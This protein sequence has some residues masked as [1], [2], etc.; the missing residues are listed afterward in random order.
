[1]MFIGDKFFGGEEPAPRESIPDLDEVRRLELAP[2]PP[3]CIQTFSAEGDFEY[4]NG[5]RVALEYARRSDFAS[6]LAFFVNTSAARGGAPEAWRRW[7]WNP[8]APGLASAAFPDDSVLAGALDQTGLRPA[9]LV[10]GWRLHVD[11][12]RV[13]PDITCSEEFYLFET[14]SDY[15]FARYYQELLH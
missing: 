7:L 5:W 1:M 2:Q 9:E 4:Y 13:D 6:L 12:G 14:E 3:A 15:I 8:L 11:H 10:Q